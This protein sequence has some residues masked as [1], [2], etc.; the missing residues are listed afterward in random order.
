MLVRGLKAFSFVV[1][2]SWGFG[3]CFMVLLRLEYYWG[4][5]TVRG[6]GRVGGVEGGLG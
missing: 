2:R 5:R 1:C 3:C 6:L 4:G